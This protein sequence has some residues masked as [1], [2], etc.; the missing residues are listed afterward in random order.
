MNIA[1]ACTKIAGLEDNVGVTV[2]FD[3]PDSMNTEVFN[4]YLDAA[5]LNGH[6]FNSK[7]L[8]LLLLMLNYSAGCGWNVN[9]LLELATLSSNVQVVFEHHMEP[10]PGFE[11]PEDE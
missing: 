7:H 2:D 1:I 6:R 8:N 10:K 11:F 3:A 9:T 5:V 4:D